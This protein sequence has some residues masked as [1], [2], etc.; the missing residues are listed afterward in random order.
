[1]TRFH[2]IFPH[3]ALCI[4]TLAAAAL[5]PWAPVSA[6]AQDIPA[7]LILIS[8]PASYLGVNIRDLD[9]HAARMLGMKKAQGVEV[10]AV[11]HDAPAGKA[12]IHLRDVILAVD[13]RPVT[14]AQQFR[15]TM[16]G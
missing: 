7:D 10:T 15:E 13:G 9:D 3:S 16:R 11:D 8:A 5:L 1:M 14:S 2:S 4:A 6:A 12:G